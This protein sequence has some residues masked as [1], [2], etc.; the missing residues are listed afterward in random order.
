LGIRHDRPKQHGQQSLCIHLVHFG[1]SRPYGSSSLGLN[2]PTTFCNNFRL[3]FAKKWILS[4]IPL[5][6]FLQSNCRWSPGKFS[7]VGF[8]FRWQL[9][10][11]LEA[12]KSA[13]P[14]QTH[15]SIRVIMHLGYHTSCHEYPFHLNFFYHY[16]SHYQRDRSQNLT[17]LAAF[18]LFQP[19]I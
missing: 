18:C 12:Q 15:K 2:T 9:L 13:G 14:L 16:A 17:A 5:L 7:Q 8:L 10:C 19:R 4:Y 3:I 11:F 1:F 6:H